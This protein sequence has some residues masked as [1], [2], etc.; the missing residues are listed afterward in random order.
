MAS[1]T[2]EWCWCCCCA[3][4]LLRPL[5][6]DVVADTSSKRARS[7]S[8]LRCTVASSS[9]RSLHRCISRW[10]CSRKWCT[11]SATLRSDCLN[12]TCRRLSL[13]AATRRS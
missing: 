10:F 1:H 6:A 3:I 2:M 11:T 7:S 4:L 12:E 8:F 5:A 13:M 9:V